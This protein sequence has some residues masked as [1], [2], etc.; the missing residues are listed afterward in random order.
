M[1]DRS[2]ERTNGALPAHDAGNECLSQSV[3]FYGVSRTDPDAKDG[4]RDQLY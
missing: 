1:M 3:N 2:A 4:R